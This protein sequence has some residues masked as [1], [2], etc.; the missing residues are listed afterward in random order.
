MGRGD[1]TNGQWVRLELLLPSGIKSV[2]P[3]VWTRRQLIDGIR[4]RTRTGA[5][6][7]DVPERFGPWD[8]VYDLFRR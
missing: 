6:W 3:P 4:R 8:W 7:R 2:R 5:P 1:L